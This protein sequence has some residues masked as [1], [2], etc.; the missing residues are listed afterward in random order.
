MASWFTVSERLHSALIL[1]ERL[2]RSGELVRV[3]E[4]A[5]ELGLSVGYLE[6]VASRLKKAGLVEAKTGPSGG[7]RLAQPISDVSFLAFVEAVEGPI[8]LVACQSKTGCAATAVCRSR[9]VW[10]RLQQQL[11]TQFQSMTLSDVLS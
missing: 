8:D 7:Y 6:E 4:V 1:V 2:A 10:D 5:T 9:H 3:S 11:K